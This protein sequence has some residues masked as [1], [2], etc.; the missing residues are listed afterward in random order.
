MKRIK[1]AISQQSSLSKSRQLQDYFEREILS[2]KMPQGSQIPPEQALATELGISRGTVRAAIQG[3]VAQGLC[4]RRRGDGTYVR[5]SHGLAARPEQE[6]AKVCVLIHCRS[7][8]HLINP[9]VTSILQGLQ[10]GLDGR[11]MEHVLFVDERTRIEHISDE[12]EGALALILL[13][14]QPSGLL[15]SLAADDRRILTVGNNFRQWNFP[16][17]NVD[18]VAGGYLAARHLLEL[19]ASRLVFLLSSGDTPDF[20]ERLLGSQQA[21]GERGGMIP[22]VA[23]FTLEKNAPGLAAEWLHA[24]YADLKPEGILVSKDP[25]AFEVIAALRST[26]GRPHKTRVVG[27]DDLYAGRLSIPSLTTVNAPNQLL[28]ERAAAFALSRAGGRPVNELLQPALIV[29]DSTK[30]GV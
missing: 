13:G 1:E 29:R 12:I 6:A 8:F 30:L 3:L 28:G 23:S 24:N 16:S 22:P 14:L 2:G 9:I 27:F 4:E 17:L 21:V 26:P 19:G 5:L 11:A 10:K 18:H 15:D 25:H 7:S 20:T